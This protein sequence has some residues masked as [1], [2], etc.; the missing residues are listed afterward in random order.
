MFRSWDAST[1]G[2]NVEVFGRVDSIVR[3]EAVHLR[4]RMNARSMGQIRPHRTSE[5]LF[6]NRRHTR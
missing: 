4:R 6:A 2:P 5:S 1:H 3:G